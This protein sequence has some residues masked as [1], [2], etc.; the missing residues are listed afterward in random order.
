M[1]TMLALPMVR[2]CWHS[3]FQRSR[4]LV[5]VTVSGGEARAEAVKAGEAGR[6]IRG[7]PGP[8]R[9]CRSPRASNRRRTS[10][11]LFGGKK[12][13]L[14]IRDRRYILRSL[15]RFLAELFSSRAAAT[16]SIVCLAFLVLV[17]SMTWFAL[18]TGGLVLV[19]ICGIAAVIVWQTKK[20]TG[21]ASA[22]WTSA[23]RHRPIPRIV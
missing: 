13:K 16:V 10:I 22:E 1:K 23:A 6:L 7:A 11:G 12:G 4:L 8:R 9:R 14:E 20:Q 19:V 18:F 17:L 5:I 21:S 3:A 15:P 2:R